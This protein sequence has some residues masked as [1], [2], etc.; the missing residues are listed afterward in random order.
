MLSEKQVDTGEIQMQSSHAGNGAA[1]FFA[2]AVAIEREAAARYD[3]FARHMRDQAQDTAEL[4]SRLAREDLEHARNLR[5]RNHVARVS[6]GEYAWLDQGAPQSAAHEWVFRL[7]SP[8]CALEIA[9]RAEDRARRFFEQV[10]LSA[11][12][13]R[14]KAVAREF[15]Q[16]ESEHI[17]RMR[18][19]LVNLPSLDW[20]KVYESGG[21]LAEGKGRRA[22]ARKPRGA[23]GSG[24]AR[25]AAPRRKA[26]GKRS[27]A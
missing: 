12:D 24:D 6:P 3:E 2:H 27:A 17:A 9:M 20:E 4:F 26:A 11:G 25:K 15:L 23:N 13:R 1:D 5:R 22:A 19:A 7:M 8:R 16:E 14:M 21:P 18:R 10:L